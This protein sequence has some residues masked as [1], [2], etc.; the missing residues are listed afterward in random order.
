MLEPTGTPQS[1]PQPI[2]SD[3]AGGID[4]GPRNVM[5]DLQNPNLFI[6]PSTDAGLIPNCR[7]SFSDTHM[8]LSHG[9]WSR[10][11]TIRE[12]P[13]ATTLA[14][15]NMSLTPGGVRELHW[16]QQAEWAYMLIGHAEHSEQYASYVKAAAKLY[17]IGTT[18]EYNNFAKHTFYLIVHSHLSGVSHKE[19]LMIAA[20]ASFRSKGKAKAEL[21]PYEALITPQDIEVICQLGTVLQLAIALDRSE[22]QGIEEMKLNL[23]DDKLHLTIKSASSDLQLE[24]HNVSEIASDFKKLWGIKPILDKKIKIKI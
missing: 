3:G 11:I 21:K 16:H 23:V 8:T 18:I 6:P 5:R 1:I 10:E 13:I 17:R 15:V 22:T 4:T 9:G 14:G 7:F 2:R 19:I 24:A 20:I 12:L